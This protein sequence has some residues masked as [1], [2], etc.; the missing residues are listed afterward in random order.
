LKT[1]E[2]RVRRQCETA[3]AVAEFL[4]GHPKIERVH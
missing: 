3:M 2:I 4:E 1:L